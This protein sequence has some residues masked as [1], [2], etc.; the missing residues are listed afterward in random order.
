[1]NADGKPKKW[2][3]MC[4]AEKDMANRCRDLIADDQSRF[5]DDV[6]RWRDKY[7]EGC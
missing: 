6:D 7:R 1:M 2:G 4:A 5:A 3:D